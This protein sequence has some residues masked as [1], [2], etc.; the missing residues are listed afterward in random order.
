MLALSYER[1]KVPNANL[2]SN[3]LLKSLLW[4]P[5]L[6]STKEGILKQT[7]SGLN[8]GLIPTYITIFKN[9]F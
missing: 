1:Y 2:L 4:N 3:T 6:S 7:P 8:S 5:T 9:C